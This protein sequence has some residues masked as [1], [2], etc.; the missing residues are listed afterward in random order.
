MKLWLLSIVEDLQTR[1][2]NVPE[3]NGRRIA[4][5]VVVIYCFHQLYP[6]YLKLENILTHTSSFLSMLALKPDLEGKKCLDFD[7]VLDLIDPNCREKVAEAI[8]DLC[9]HLAHHKMLR[10]PEWLYALPLLHFLKKDSSP[11]QIQELNPEKMRWGDKYLGLGPVRSMAY[12]QEFG[13]VR[14]HSIVMDVFYIDL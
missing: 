2:N 14:N 6:H 12:D 10:N 4:S 3:E 11:F 9:R 1:P 5:I 7:Y 13:Y 8:S